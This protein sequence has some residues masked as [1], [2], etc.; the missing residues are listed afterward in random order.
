MPD[1]K[2]RTGKRIGED[3]NEKETLGGGGG[4]ELK[5]DANCRKRKDHRK[6]SGVERERTQSRKDKKDKK[7]EKGGGETALFICEKIDK[8]TKKMR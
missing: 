8:P 2:A 3:R 6:G 1:R 7:S 4:R 5:G